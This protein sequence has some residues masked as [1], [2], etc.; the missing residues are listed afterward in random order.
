ME[1]WN[2]ESYQSHSNLEGFELVNILLGYSVITALDIL[3]HDRGLILERGALT[4]GDGSVIDPDT[5]AERE[6]SLQQGVLNCLV[7]NLLCSVRP[8]LDFWTRISE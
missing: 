2:I 1:Y 8:H 5:G 3:K 4:R 7:G 6:I